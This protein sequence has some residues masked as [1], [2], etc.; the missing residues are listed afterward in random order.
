VALKIQEYIPLPTNNLLLTNNYIPSY[1]NSRVS[2]VPSIK[3]D[4]SLSS[5]LKLSGYWSR[6]QTDSPNNSGLEYPIG[7]TVGSHVKADTYRVNFDYTV[8]PTLL[9]HI[10]AGYLY[11]RSDPDVPR[12]DNSKIGFKGTNTDL[13]PYFSVLSQAQGGMTNFGP[14]SDFRIKNLKPTGTIS[15]TWV[16]NNHTYKAGGELIVNGYPSF[17]ET[18]SSGNMLYS[19]NQS[20]DPSLDGR[21]L[22]A[23]VGFNYAS[24][25]LGSPNTGYDSVPASMRSGNHS[26][27]GFAQDSWKVTRKLTIDYGLRY[28]FQTY[29]KEHNG[30]MFN[31]SMATPNPTAGGRLGAIIFEGYGGGRC[32]CAFAK[33]YPWAYQPRLGVAYQINS[34]TV[35]R[36]GGGISYSKTSND[37][38][39]ASN[40][41]STKP[42]APPEYGTPPFTL[43][44]GMP[45]QISFPDF[46][47]GQQPLPGTV[48]NPTNMV[49]QNAGR[50]ARIWQWTIGL[51]REL[52]KNL[53]VEASY[54]GNRGVWW[55]AQTL[56]PWASNA[57]PFST[58]AAYGLSLDN[59]ADR[60]LL[61]APLNSAL[62]AQR[63][64]STPPYP[65]F[66]VGLTV[67]QSLRP[68][69]QFT[70]IVQTWNPLGNT[71]YDALQAK[72][73]KRFSHGLDAV[74]TYTYSKSLALGAEE[75][76][77]Y[78]STTTPVINDVFNRQNNKT[79][80]G[81]DQ[82]QALIVAGNYTTPKVMAGAPG[83][84]D[85]LIS[86]A[87]GDWTAGAVLRYASG[88]PFKVPTATTNLSSFIFQGT[89]VDRVP[90]VPLYTQDL[91]CHCFDPNS[92]FVLNPAA[93]AN[94]ALGHFGSANAH[95]GDY[96]MQRRPQES[97]SLAR[98]FR[99]KE[100]ASLQIRAEFSNIFNRA[101]INVPTATNAFATQ[102]RINGQTS[103]GFGYI[104]S[105]AVGGAASNP[106]AASAA[107]FA[108]PQPRQG[109]LVVRLQ[110]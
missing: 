54:V 38:S 68:A 8:T 105:A 43:R 79:L 47:P 35:F 23:T 4:H 70:G 27:A 11:S 71:W 33:N 64:F 15:L 100:R 19:S 10:G 41:G 31:V 59:A 78:G 99:F 9:L 29:L 82:P 12:F 42:F 74:V 93:W 17:S 67:A 95:Y 34:K 84:L 72:A 92:N 89:N 57:I 24:F 28:D 32:N 103:G 97:V 50:P 18:Y 63:G 20:A 51:Q 1:S 21:S 25:L 108:T 94:P 107:T 45:Y 2:Q 91:N 60:S 55:A 22:P 49:D 44:G 39:K 37:A 96:R 101:G 62:A 3:L 5:R 90:G 69:P 14:P 65:G 7:V 85:K 61:A 102:T 53:V 6:T 109:T 48:G 36:A 52:S 13:F 104:P 83:L 75:N 58:L 87:V 106:A 40:F 76:N 66:P 98:N 16:R 56:S 81:F 86:W 46:N 26:L 88:F 30:Y 73:T 80:S 77:N 110:F